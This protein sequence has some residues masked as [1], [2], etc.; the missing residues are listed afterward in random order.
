MVESFWTTLAR[1]AAQTQGVAIPA[2]THLKTGFSS[3]RLY[4]GSTEVTPIHPFKIER[5][6]D[7]G[8]VINEGV[9]VFDPAAVGPS[10]GTVKLTLFS[11]KAPDKPDTR[12]LDAKLLQQIAQDFAYLKP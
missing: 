10:C 5:H 2:I 6:M 7:Q 11:E 12:T 4:C 9:Y 3:M 1:G 8:Q